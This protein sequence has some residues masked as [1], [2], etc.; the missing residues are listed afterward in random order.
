M[1]RQTCARCC[2]SR[3][4]WATGSPMATAPGQQR[5]DRSARGALAAPDPIAGGVRLS[6]ASDFDGPT[7]AVLH[8]A[9]WLAGDDRSERG[10][11][12]RLR[13]LG[14]GAARS[15]GAPP[16]RVGALGENRR[17][18]RGFVKRHGEAVVRE[19]AAALAS[20]DVPSV[21]SREARQQGAA[22]LAAQADEAATGVAADLLLP[23]ARALDVAV[24]GRVRCRGGG[25]RPR[26]ISWE[27]CSRVVWGSSLGPPVSASDDHGGRNVFDTQAQDAGL[28]THI[29]LK[30]FFTPAENCCGWQ[31]G[32]SI[33]RRGARNRAQPSWPSNAGARHEPRP[34]SDQ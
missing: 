16:R 31:R 17:I 11:T 1:R 10:S 7:R 12:A 23:P 34:P 32:W 21:P 28:S 8:Q 9:A 24:R 29:G 14:R 3:R 15:G 25:S 20:D 30:N 26:G 2:A 27:G 22:R 6:I 5:R 4:V 13:A 19:I 33:P 18:A